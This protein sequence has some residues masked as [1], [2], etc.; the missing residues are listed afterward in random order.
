M[1][2]GRPTKFKPEFAEQAR[3]LAALGA[4]DREAAEFFALLPTEDDWLYACLCLIRQDRRGVISVHKKRRAAA[5][6]RS[7]ADSPSRRLLNAIRARLW[8]A[9]RGKSDGALLSRLGFSLEQL[10]KH[11]ESQFAD[12]MSWGNYGRWHVDHEKPCATFDQ[13]DP[14]Q[15]SEC[16][17]LSNLQPLWA[18][19]NLR[20]GAKRGAA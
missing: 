17:A 18:A 14:V 9:L 10:R 6:R 1:P 2:A 12:G 19:D 4:T 16:W 8:A 11:I 5:K 13:T 3:K 20:K 15:F 7:L